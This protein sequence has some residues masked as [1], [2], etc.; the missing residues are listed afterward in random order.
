[1]FGHR[2]LKNPIYHWEAGGVEIWLIRESFNALL[3]TKL[4]RN[5]MGKLYVLPLAAARW[6]PH[7]TEGTP[8]AATL[9]CLE[10]RRCSQLC[11]FCAGRK[12]NECL[13][14]LWC[15][16]SSALPMPNTC[17][18]PGCRSGYEDTTEKVSLFCSPSNEKLHE[19][20]KC[21]VPQ[22]GTDEFSFNSKCVWVCEKHFSGSY[23][24]C[25]FEWIRFE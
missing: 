8:R 3:V 12:C 17:C 4:L 16:L 6:R 23:I 5:S 22:K 11:L 2:M 21:T 1:M 9:R 13:A 25:S 15:D 14:L 20:R 10:R 24:I 19:K 18:V 7:L